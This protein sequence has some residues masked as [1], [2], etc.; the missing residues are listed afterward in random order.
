MVN[1]L[2]SFGVNGVSIFQGN[3]ATPCHYATRG[4]I[5]NTHGGCALHG[6]SHQLGLLNL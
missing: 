1:G 6:T 2:M 5:C 4:K 3:C